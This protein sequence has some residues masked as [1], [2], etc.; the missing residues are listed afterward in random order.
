MI[1]KYYGVFFLNKSN[2]EIKKKT[3]TIVLLCLLVMIVL[4]GRLINIMVFKSD[5]YQKKADDLHER[6]RNIKAA[7]GEIL[8][9][10]GVVLAANKTV[11]T[12]SVI[13][14]Q[15]TD[16]EKVIEVL[17][18]C[19]GIDR[20]E[21]VKKVEKVSSRE[22]IKSNVDKEIGDKIRQY[23][24]DGVKV[25]ED[26]KR[27]YPYGSLASKV[28]G[29]T[30][31][32]NQGIIGLE[33]QYD[34]FLMGKDG[35]ILTETD[36]YGIERENIVEKRVE[37]VKGDNLVTSIDYNI[38]EYVTQAALKV[39]EEK[40]ANYVAIIVM[41]P[42]NGEIYAMVNVPEFDLNKPYELNIEQAEGEKKMDALNKMW[43][44]QSI[45]DTYEP[46]STFKI[47]TAT[48]GLETGV[49]NVNSTFSCPG[50]R[51]VEDR[52]IR[53][54]K[55]SGHGSENFVQGT[56]NS[57]N[58]VF[59]DVG[60][61]IG[62]ENY[63]T[64]LK[65]LGLLEKTGIDLPGEAKTIIHKIENVGEVEL[66]TMSFG[67]SFQITPLQLLRAVSA[68]VNG[69]TLITPHFGIRTVDM[70]NNITN[71]FEYP[72]VENVISKETSE[73]M[74]YILEKV[75]SE[76]GGKKGQVE[77]YAVSGKTATSE[78]LPR[79]SGKYIGSFIGF[80][81]SD[82]PQ[83]IAICIVDEPVGVYYG[84]T[85]AAPVVADIFSNILPYLGIEKTYTTN[86]E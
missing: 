79:G 30:G 33:V 24:L 50:F 59:I 17:T 65:R 21:I 4:V 69:G 6:E 72:Q 58:P 60:L 1:I 82:N 15:I 57:C 32:D 12:V 19:L 83:V 42:Q 35:K 66:A 51:V 34:K 18:E 7:R 73:T 49:V 14:S 44:N 40:A 43:R 26:Y 53:C 80:A 46:G 85:I 37:A 47:V 67:Q 9:R 76:G 38:Q 81:P 3:F 10:N 86:E 48:A 54:H 16:K 52:R 75:V 39:R 61:R 11:C 29:F 77:G 2:T 56:M 36:A 62:K 63:Y 25:D 78:K 71:E 20:A 5:Y 70:D 41:N 8:D 22:K 74:K 27:F 23:N 45:N 55:V 31:S 84:G 68:V 64:Y 28:M 13:H